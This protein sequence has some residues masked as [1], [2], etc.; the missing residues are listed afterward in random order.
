MELIEEINAKTKSKSSH[1]SRARNTSL[2]DERSVTRV[3]IKRKLMRR[4][5]DPAD[6]KG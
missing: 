1:G 2:V 6:Q 4:S 5:N 3:D